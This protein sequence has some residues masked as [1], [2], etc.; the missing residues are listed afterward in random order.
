MRAVFLDRDGV[1]N[2]NVFYKDTQAWES[3]RNTA[4]FAIV[5]SAIQSMQLLQQANF[6]LFIVSN[7]PNYA[8]GKSSLEE[9]QAIHSKLSH[10]LQINNITV[11]ETYYCYHHPN[12]VVANYSKVC[13]CRKPSPFFLLAAQK[14]YSIDM[15][16]SWMIGDRD[17]DITCG[18]M[19][20]TQTI[21]II[22][23]YLTNYL[24]NVEIEKDNHP[25]LRSAVNNILGITP[26]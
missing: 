5:P 2:Y 19:A 15:A 12:G 11:T 3:P 17:T 10:E 26:C 22:P 24:P 20:G 21:K 13:Q 4:D 7:Q 9:L 25:N 18:K 6:L 16:N 14:T 1:I 23:D 8:K